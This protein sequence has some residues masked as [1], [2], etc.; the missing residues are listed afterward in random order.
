MN[1]KR[2]FQISF[3]IGEANILLDALGK[4]PFNQ[5]YQLIRKIQQQAAAQLNG[6][7][8]DVNLVSEESDKE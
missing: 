8:E 4:Q 3:S 1:E 6:K 7:P 2:E 5:V